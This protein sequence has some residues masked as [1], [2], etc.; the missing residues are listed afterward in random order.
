MKKTILLSVLVILLL[1]ILVSCGGDEFT[2]GYERNETKE[3]AVTDIPADTKTETETETAGKEDGPS[4][5]L[6][7]PSDFSFLDAVPEGPFD[8]VNPDDSG[9]SWYPG[10]I[11]RDLTTGE[12]TVNWDRS[13]STK[14]LI[15]K[16]GAIYRG[17]SAQKIVYLTF[18]C[19]YEYRC[20][21]YPNGVTNAILDV[22]REKNVK[23]TFF[24]TGDYLN[25]D[26][27]I[28]QRMLDEGH[29]VGTHTMHHYN[30]TQITPAEFVSEIKDNNDLLK[31]K[32]PSAPDMVFYRPPEGGANERTLALAK[33]IGLSTV[34][35]SAT[36]ADYNTSAQPDPATTLN[37]DKCKLFNG[38]VYLL[39]AVSTTNAQILGDL[40]DFI[41]AS[42]YTIGTLD[43]FVR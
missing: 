21:E 6:S 32:I 38:C 26:I 25:S 1:L 15:D 16:Y 12:V 24:V 43:T 17:N 3:T 31:S 29:I 7:Y 27:D 20:D 14:A 9:S 2:D 37:N 8:D 18:D 35:W 34:F 30:M 40:I 19:G 41:Q 5:S 23:G 22:L 42:G 33:E 13:E 28:V 10:N 36:E 11:R 4:A 39:H